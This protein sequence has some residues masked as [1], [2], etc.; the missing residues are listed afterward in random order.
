MCLLNWPGKL[1]DLA[2]VILSFICRS[3]LMKF[4]TKDNLG[5]LVLYI[6]NYSTLA[7]NWDTFVD[8]VVIT[9]QGLE[10][11]LLIWLLLPGKDWR[12]IRWFGC[13][14]LARTGDT[15]VDFLLAGFPLV[16][17]LALATKHV[18]HYEASVISPQ[19]F[20]QNKQKLHYVSYCKDENE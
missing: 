9:W 11:H 2:T 6:V 14:Y 10:I 18:K 13:Y 17:W 1:W 3:K 16:A 8:L 15:F 20:N 4:P 12:Y 7:R 19:K 5:C